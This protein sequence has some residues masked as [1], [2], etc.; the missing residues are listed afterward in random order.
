MPDR[1]HGLNSSRVVNIEDLRRLGQRRLPEQSLMI[2]MVVRKPSSHYRA[3]RDVIFLPRSAAAIA[4]CTT[5]RVLGHELSFPALLAPVGH[6][7]CV[8]Y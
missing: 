1:H 7:H 8:G 5:T 4:N 3:F 6:N 2:S